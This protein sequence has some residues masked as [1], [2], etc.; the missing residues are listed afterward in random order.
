MNI[1]NQKATLTCPQ[2]H[3]KQ[4]AVIPTEGKQHFFKCA[5]E[6]C[7]ANIFVKKDECCVFCVHGDVAC[8]NNKEVEEESSQLKSL[9]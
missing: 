5:N 1:N 8:A 9:I 4:K 2:C 3:H 6:E 7:G